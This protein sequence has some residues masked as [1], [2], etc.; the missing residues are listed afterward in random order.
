MC[1]TIFAGCMKAD[2]ASFED[3]NALFRT[4]TASLVFVD[5]NN[6]GAS[7]LKQADYYYFELDVGTKNANLRQAINTTESSNFTM[8]ANSKEY[9]VLI[10]HAEKYFFRRF[11]FLSSYTKEQL[12]NIKQKDLTALYYQ[13]QAVTET[14]DAFGKDSRELASCYNDL[15]PES[16]STQYALDDLLNTYKTLIGKVIDMNMTAQQI[17]DGSLFSYTES[18]DVE[19]SEVYRLANAFELYTAKYL[20]MRYMA[21]DQNT[22]ISFLN[23]SL[24]QKLNK[25]VELNGSLQKNATDRE[26]YEYMLLVEKGIRTEFEN[27]QNALNVLN[28]TVPTSTDKNYE[29]KNALYTHFVE[30][31]NTMCEYLDKIISLLR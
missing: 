17:I 6:V 7:I 11:A 14:I 16:K 18:E 10:G 4:N 9:G 26:T 8:L 30:Y 2:S 25:M 28:K 23:N 13:V 19:E 22:Q 20:Y 5:N 31:E 12:A 1:T 15:T 29:Y 27:L 21:F 3:V 24:T